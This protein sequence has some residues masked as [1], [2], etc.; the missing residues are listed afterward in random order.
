MA[1][2]RPCPQRRGAGALRSTGARHGLA[3][4]IRDKRDQCLSRPQPSI[5]GGAVTEEPQQ[6]GR[7]ATLS[8]AF[9]WLS[10]GSKRQAQPQAAGPGRDPGIQRP[11]AAQA[12]TCPQPLSGAP[13][14][15]LPTP[16]SLVLPSSTSFLLGLH[17]PLCSSGRPQPLPPGSPPEF[18]VTST[19]GPFWTP[20]EA[21]LFL[22]S[23]LTRSPPSTISG[24]S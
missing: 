17:P 21:P 16:R 22:L 9:E 6:K 3:S 14:I 10:P 1:N 13:P 12:W 18:N 8:E 4:V 24:A 7:R 5:P 11:E 19:A 2:A 20:W 15:P 23:S